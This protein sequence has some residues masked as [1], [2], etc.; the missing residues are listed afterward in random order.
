MR[1]KLGYSTIIYMYI[2]QENLDTE[3]FRSATQ[4]TVIMVI[5]I[6]QCLDD[7]WDSDT[8]KTIV[9]SYIY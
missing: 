7:V 3:L 1:V 9:L 5:I 2:V 8:C 4:V 6:I